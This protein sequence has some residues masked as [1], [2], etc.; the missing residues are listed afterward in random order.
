MV[1]SSSIVF[2]LYLFICLRMTDGWRVTLTLLHLFQ[3]YCSQVI[4]SLPKFPQELVVLRI[5]NQ[6]DRNSLLNIVRWCF[7]GDLRQG[8]YQSPEE[9]ASLTMDISCGPESR[10][11]MC[12]QPFTPA[13]ASWRPRRQSWQDS[14]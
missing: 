2:V 6:K 4:G 7:F 3:D 13:Q 9:L 1:Q 5:Q 11:P 8:P 14:D 12:R 10:L